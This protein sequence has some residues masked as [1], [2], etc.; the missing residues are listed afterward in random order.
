[1]GERPVE[2]TVRPIATVHNSRTEAI[3]DNWAAIP[4]EIRLSDEL[5]EACLD[6]IEAFSHLE[7]VY[8][9]HKALDKPPVLG[10]EHPRENPA[11]PK[12]GIF[13]QRKKARP[14][15]L[16]CTIV[17]LLRRDGRT[18]HV[19]HLDAIDG[20]PVLDIKPVLREFLPQ[21]PVFQPAWCDELM[22][23]YWCA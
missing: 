3:D 11:W 20:T 12:V 21:G 17:N 8:L 18:L 4:S 19:T 13:A 22:K 1:M 6:G 14:N 16:A 7:I 10:S 23:N 2:F 15:H 9:V 5:P